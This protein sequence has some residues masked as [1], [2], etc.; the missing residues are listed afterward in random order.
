VPRAIIVISGL[1]LLLATR[2]SVC[3]VDPD[4]WHEM[5]LGREIVRL[6]YVPYHDTF[7]YT[8]TVYP[9]VHHEWGAG[10]LAYGIAVTLGSTGIVVLKYLLVFALAV[11][12]WRCARDRGA[13]IELLSMLAPVAILLADLG[14]STVRAQMYSYLAAA[15]L[16]FLFY[17]GRLRRVRWVVTWLVIWV[18]WLNLHAGFLVGGGWFALHWLEQLVRKRPHWHLFTIGIAMAGLVV[19]NPYGIH[20]YAYL[21]LATSLDRPYVAEWAPVWEAASTYH[22]VLYVASLFLLI[23][24][25]GVRRLRGCE[26]LILVVVTAYM[27]AQHT[28]LLP[29]YAIIWICYLPRYLADGPIAIALQ[30]V[31]ER[32][33]RL[34]KSAFAI[35]CLLVLAR[36]ATMEPLQLIVP[37]RPLANLDNGFSYPVGATAYLQDV[38]Y[39]G[40]LMAHFN[41]GSYVMWKLSPHVKVSLDGRYEVA[42]LPS[43]AEQV[44]RLYLRGENWESAL[45]RFETDAVLVPTWSE[46]GR[47]MEQQE[48]GKRDTAV[49][50]WRSVYRD[51][52]FSLYVQHDR[53]ERLP[54][55]DRSGEVIR[56]EFP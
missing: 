4:L 1:A 48:E 3:V 21:W 16:L 20:Y 49:P 5:S 35:A 19:L 17:S 32:W 43:F 27:A 22:L 38:G 51:D 30:N 18:V 33:D 15:T 28:R 12:C 40:N 34:L 24:A 39:R 2:I 44:H 10:L 23:Y 11:I 29:F 9:V 42:Y 47:C 26:G 8:P 53:A 41:D 37:N 50:S 54:T 55:V 45:E 52:Q 7:A 14:F 31:W 46:L 56:G 13:S 36:S 25:V 6:G